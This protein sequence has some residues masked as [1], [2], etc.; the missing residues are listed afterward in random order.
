MVLLA[1]GRP[2]AAAPEL[3]AALALRRELVGPESADV[4]Q[5]LRNLGLARL[6]LRDLTG[7][8]EAFEQSV[9]LSRRVYP[10]RHLRVAEVLAARAQL[11]LAERRR[12]DA[13]R[14]LIE[15]L[16]IREEKLGR[17]HALTAEL[18]RELA[19]ARR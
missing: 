10:A 5:S 14:D 11:A 7:A 8:R 6:A 3:T 16:A 9:E 1:L 12:D 4:A 18:R 13:A 19:R 2:R 17:D 15:A